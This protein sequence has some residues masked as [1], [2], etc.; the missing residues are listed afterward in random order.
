MKKVISI[1]LVI[2]MLSCFMV[3][4]V[5]ADETAAA[6]V[7]G[8]AV[9]GKT[10]DTVTMGINIGNNP[11]YRSFKIVLGYNADALEVASVS[12]N[13]TSNTNT[14]GKVIATFGSATKVEGDGQLFSVSFK[15][16]GGCGTYPVSVSVSELYTDGTVAL[17]YTTA[18]G[19][20]TVDH[21]WVKG[22]TVAPTCTEKGYTVY[23][24]SVCGA[25]ENRDFVD[26]AH[27]PGAA[28]KENVVVGS[29]NKPGSY[30]SVVYCSVCGV[31]LSRETIT[32]TPDD[33]QYGVDIKDDVYHTYTCKVCAHAYDEEHDVQEDDY[34]YWCEICGWEKEKPAPGPGPDPEE[35]ILGDVESQFNFGLVALIAVACGAAFVFKRKLVK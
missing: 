3:T 9:S 4:T 32:G 19:S 30:D 6:S 7:Y 21:S 1:L 12:G 25:T 27:V 8:A 22:N 16:K 10:G 29:C 17:S 35:P 31:E 28:V 26:G 14:A 24:C 23:T 13:V 33:H 2:A 15:I 20:V 11:G 5:S 18:S 34:H